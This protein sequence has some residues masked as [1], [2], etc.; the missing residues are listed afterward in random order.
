MIIDLDMPLL[1]E[2]D[3][4]RNLNSFPSTDF[5]WQPFIMLTNTHALHARFRPC[6]RYYLNNI[7]TF[8]DL[9]CWLF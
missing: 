6:R 2:R 5:A 4:V 3:P 8:S 7:D 9:N 1:P